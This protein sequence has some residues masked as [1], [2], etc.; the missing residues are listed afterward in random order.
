MPR[1]QS[2]PAAEANG[3]KRAAI[4]DEQPRS[5][6]RD[7]L[8]LLVLFVFFRLFALCFLQTAFANWSGNLDY[9]VYRRLGELALDGHLPFLHYW[10]E[11]PPVFPWVVVGV[12]YLSLQL[13]PPPTDMT[14]F[15]LLL[16]TLL[17]LFESGN[18]VLVYQL[19]KDLWGP[20]G[21]LR[22]AILYAGLFGPLYVA[23]NWFDSFPLFFLLLATWLA[24][25]RRYW[26]AGAATGLGFMVKVM[27]AVVA[28]PALRYAYS[29]GRLGYALAAGAAVAVVSLPFLA[30]DPRWLVAG[31]RATV[32]RSSWETIWALA[33]G[34]FG[35]GLVAGISQRFDPASAV[36]TNHPSVL[37]WPLINGAFLAACL[38][39]FVRR[40]RVAHPQAIA[41]GVGLTLSLFLIFSKGWSPQYVVYPLALLVVLLPNGWGVAY[42]IVLT[43][44]NFIE[45]PLYFT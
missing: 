40:S 4:V 9:S 34:Y 43:I 19:A 30:T 23:L 17:V 33:E 16:G 42:A 1:E 12:F 44:A 18:L 20:A 7:F 45:W 36:S 10:V 6:G 5:A 29:R 3:P 38:A 37:P 41:A 35:W 2:P 11:Y 13:P 28:P 25:R 15:Q 22:S 26:L 8:L 14:W 27:P 21:A 39:A 24:G 32:A 31:F